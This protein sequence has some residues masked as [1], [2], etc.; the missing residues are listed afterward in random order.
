MCDLYLQ[1]LLNGEI[2][3]KQ[4]SPSKEKKNR[5]ELEIEKQIDEHIKTLPLDESPDNKFF[6]PAMRIARLREELREESKHSELT[7]YLDQAFQ[8]IEK[9]GRKYLSEKQHQALLNE[10]LRGLALLNEVSLSQV[11]NVDFKTL[12]SIS[13]EAEDSIVLLAEKKTAETALDDCLPIYILL[14][15]LEP[16]NA[17]YWYRAAIACHCNKKYQTAIRFYNIA[18]SLDAELIGSKL[19]SCD[20]YLESNCIEEASQALKEAESISQ[21]I[22]CDAT[23]KLLISELS[24]KLKA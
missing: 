11:T 15:V 5:F 21:K 8:I 20:C 10:I 23:W 18:Y 22:E 12:L 13:D 7:K 14:S 17:T 6:T 9:E 2:S 3:G 16:K 19:F 24:T 4:L 1:A